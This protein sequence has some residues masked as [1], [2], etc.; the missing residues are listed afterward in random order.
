MLPRASL[1]R[2]SRMLTRKRWRSS[3]KHLIEAGLTQL[4]D[5]RG[6]NHVRNAACQVDHVPDSSPVEVVWSVSDDRDRGGFFLDTDEISEGQ[7]EEGSVRQVLVNVYERNRQA[8]NACI[9]HY[10]PAC[11][12]C[13][14]DFGKR[15]GDIGI[16]YIHV[17][18]LLPLSEIREVSKW[19]LSPTCDRFVR[20]ATRWHIETILRYQCQIFEVDSERSSRDFHCRRLNSYRPKAQRTANHPQIEGFARAQTRLAGTLH[21]AP[22]TVRTFTSGS[23]RLPRANARCPEAASPTCSGRS[24]IAESGAVRRRLR[25]NRFLVEEGGGCVFRSRDANPNNL[26]RRR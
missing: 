4:L 12:V 25:R 8:R 14:F 17:H 10:G 26:D 13:G 16:G 2:C 3:V 18:H 9:E 24:V 22:E 11:F 6:I 1:K 20:T 19:I 15:Y 23:F 21:N 5:K 7:F